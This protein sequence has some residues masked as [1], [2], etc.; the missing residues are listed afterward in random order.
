MNRHKDESIGAHSVCAL[1]DSRQTC[2]E[3]NRDGA[4]W[5]LEEAISYVRLLPMDG[6][7]IIADLRRHRHLVERATWT[8]KAS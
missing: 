2:N 6:D 4:L 7:A 5:N 3:C 1:A 8:R